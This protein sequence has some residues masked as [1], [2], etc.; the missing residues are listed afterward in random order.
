LD[1][2]DVPIYIRKSARIVCNVGGTS[3]HTGTGGTAGPSGSCPVTAKRCVENN[4]MVLE[5]RIDIAGSLHV[6]DWL[7][8]QRRRRPSSLDGGRNRPTREEEDV[9]VVGCPLHSID[10]ATIVIKS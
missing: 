10:A 3:R 1:R 7:S 2:F 9:N 5:I 8:P 6:C 4:L